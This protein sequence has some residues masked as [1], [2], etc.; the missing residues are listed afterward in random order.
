[1]MRII[2]VVNKNIAK[3]YGPLTTVATRTFNQIKNDASQYVVTFN[4][5][6][7]YHVTRPWQDQCVVNMETRTC[8]CR[9]W[10]LIGMMRW[11]L[12]GIWLDMVCRRVA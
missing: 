5:Q 1:M 7:K 2:G 10:E 3:C 9:K 4:G 11:L 12:T 8:S 6:G